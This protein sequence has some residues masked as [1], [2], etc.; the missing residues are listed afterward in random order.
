[1][2][3]VDAEK[4]MN[5]VNSNVRGALNVAK[6]FLHYAAPDAV[7]IETNSSV[8]HVNFVPGFSSYAVAKL[9]VYRLWGN[10]GFA[11]PNLRVY[12][13]Q[14]GIVDTDMNREAGGVKAVGFEDH[15]KPQG[16]RQTFITPC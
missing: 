2:K 11:N 15:G 4:F 13:V 12:H 8:A 5:G 1:M 6:A 16:S 14:P 3:D 7:A 10:V 9:A